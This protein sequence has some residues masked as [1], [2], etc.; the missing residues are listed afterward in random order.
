[1]LE[2]DT[3]ATPIISY[4][5]TEITFT[6]SSDGKEVQLRSGQIAEIKLPI[7]STKNMDGSLIASW[8]L[9]RILLESL[10]HKSL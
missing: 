2:G 8:R 1:M 5:T 10:I 3:D 9:L 6:R 4:G 7:Y